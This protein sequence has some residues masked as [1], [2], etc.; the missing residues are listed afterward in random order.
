MN[1]DFSRTE[2]NVRMDWKHDIG[3][4]NENR[5]NVYGT[6]VPLVHLPSRKTFQGLGFGGLLIA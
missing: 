4:A 5:A 6:R 2:R 3:G 1:T